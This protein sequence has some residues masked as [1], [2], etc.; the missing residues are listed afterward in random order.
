MVS[1]FILGY[2]YPFERRSEWRSEMWNETFI[3]VSIYFTMFFSA[4]ISNVDV[5]NGIGYCF[6]GLLF[7]HLIINI[8]IIAVSTIRQKIKEFRHWMIIRREK[9]R[10]KAYKKS[11]VIKWLGYTNMK[12]LRKR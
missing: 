4:Y 10:M 7:S 1:V 8:T 6:C 9:L 12:S 11:K 2:G 5:L 3:L